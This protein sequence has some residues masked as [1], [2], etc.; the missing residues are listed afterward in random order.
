[1]VLAQFIPRRL[2]SYCV[3]RFVPCHPVSSRVLFRPVSSRV[4]FH[5]V[6][7]RVI[8]CPPV[9]RFVLCHPRVIPFRPM[10][11]RVA[12]R[13]VSSHVI[14]CHPVSRF[15]P[16]CHPLSSRF[17]PCHP[18][19][20]RVA[21]R[22][23]SSHVIPCHPVSSCPRLQAWTA[24]QP[25]TEPCRGGKVT[26][27]SVCPPLLRITWY[28]AC[29]WPRPPCNLPS[30]CRTA[31]CLATSPRCPATPQLASVWRTG[32]GLWRQVR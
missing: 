17:V 9:S 8:P 25:S 21:F 7:S 30:Q 20:S 14:L 10:S 26:T 4:P 28:R 18:V 12:F 1:M 15:V 11:S 32:T 22:P 16:P 29:H 27:P 6:S 23:V 19:S 13:P 24:G 5:P 3:T 2:S 31:C